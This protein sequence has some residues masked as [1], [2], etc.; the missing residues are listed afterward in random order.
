MRLL[1]N[2]VRVWY[3]MAAAAALS[4]ALLDPGR[5]LP[6][7]IWVLVCVHGVVCSKSAPLLITALVPWVVRATWT[8]ETVLLCAAYGFFSVA[9]EMDGRRRPPAA[10]VASDS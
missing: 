4:A 3:C 8:A 9:Y 7:L 1:R 2:D 10:A 6:W 5:N